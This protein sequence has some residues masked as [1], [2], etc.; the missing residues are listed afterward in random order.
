MR[1]AAEGISGVNAAMA[2]GTDGALAALG[3][4]VLA[5]TRAPRSSTR[6]RRWSAPPCSTRIPRSRAAL[7]PVFRSLTL[8]A[9]QQLNARIAVDGETPR[10]VAADYLAGTGFLK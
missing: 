1:A 8:S 2:Y 3:L 7:D 4:V 9:L 10:R 5:T 6:R